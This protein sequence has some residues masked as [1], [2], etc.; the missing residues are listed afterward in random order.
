MQIELSSEEMALCISA[1]GEAAK[2]L[3]EGQA[4]SERLGYGKQD[5]LIAVAS[6]MDSLKDRL[7]GS[8]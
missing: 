8:A 1:L 7:L 6:A 4:A 2:D 5:G 3:R